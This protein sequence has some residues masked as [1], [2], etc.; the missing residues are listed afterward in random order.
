MCQIVQYFFL[1]TCRCLGDEWSI[2]KETIDDI[3]A[4]TC[5]MYG[6]PRVKS[7]DI[8]R[9]LMLKKMVGEDEEL[10]TKS[11]VDLARLPPC[12]DNLVPHI[13]RVN[14]RLATYKRAD[15]G[16]F[17]CPKPHEPEQGWEKTEEGTLEPI[18]SL[19]PILPP[20]LIDLIDRAV[21]EV[22]NLEE[23]ETLEIDYDELLYDNE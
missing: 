12:K 19:G 6:Q 14:H 11:K 18:W 10:T 3:E 2:K 7:I 23:E 22:L 4:F 8:V 1:Y 15:Q 21:E 17:W 5:L 9:S 16:I 13:Y 20:T